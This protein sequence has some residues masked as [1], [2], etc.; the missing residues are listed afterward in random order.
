MNPVITRKNLG[1]LEFDGLN[2]AIEKRFSNSWAA[3]AVYAVGY[4]R[5]DSEPNQLYVNNYQVLDDPNLDLQSGPLDNDRRQ[6][7]VLSGRVE[8]PRTGGLILS[9]IYRWM[10][11]VPMTL[12]DTMSLMS[13][14]RTAVQATTVICLLLG[15]SAAQAQDVPFAFLMRQRVA[16]VLRRVAVR[17]DQAMT[18]WYTLGRIH[19]I[20]NTQKG[21]EESARPICK[22]FHAPFPIHVRHARPSGRAHQPQPGYATRTPHGASRRPLVFGQP[23]QSSIRR[24]QPISGFPVPGPSETAAPSAAAQP[25]RRGRRR[26]RRFGNPL[27]ARQR[28]PHDFGAVLPPGSVRQ[29][30]VLL[31]SSQQLPTAVAGSA[32]AP[33]ITTRRTDHAGPMRS[34]AGQVLRRFHRVRS[35][36]STPVATTTWCSPAVRPR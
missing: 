3:R 27:P 28:Y 29:R 22:S 15:A 21:A 1:T 6:N 25:E 33:G 26:H 8:V 2:V 35:R 10:S 4:A 14:C 30:P 17:I 23:W 36:C 12:F 9:G 19:A 13:R 20:T 24:R 18:S 5:G 11:G 32:P 31:R 16:G 7:I 34:D